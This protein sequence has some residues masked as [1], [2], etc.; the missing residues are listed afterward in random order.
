MVRT[1]MELV[2]VRVSHRR[3]WFSKSHVHARKHEFGFS[4][5]TYHSD[6]YPRG[7]PIKGKVD[8]HRHQACLS[9]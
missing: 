7:D 1:L 3:N 2:V 8:T 6:E 4:V 5:C 9:R